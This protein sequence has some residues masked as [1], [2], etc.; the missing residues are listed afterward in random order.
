MSVYP[1]NINI[2]HITIEMIDG[3]L[4]RQESCLNHYKYIPKIIRN[5]RRNHKEN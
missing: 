4:F 2:K 1:Y 3:H 5:L